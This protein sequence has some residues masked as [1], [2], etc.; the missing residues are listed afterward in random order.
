M[1][2]TINFDQQNLLPVACEGFSKSEVPTL[3]YKTA[4]NRNQSGK[5]FCGRRE[6]IVEYQLRLDIKLANG[7][8]RF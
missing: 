2:E 1:A 4:T 6:V 3:K 7:V 5:L 8:F